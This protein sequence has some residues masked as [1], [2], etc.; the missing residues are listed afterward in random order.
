VEEAVVLRQSLS[1]A[2]FQ[3]LRLCCEDWS[4]EE[5]APE[6]VECR[7]CIAAKGETDGGNN[8]DE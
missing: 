3:E 7:A 5:F 4:R 6:T 1:K 8:F 2:R